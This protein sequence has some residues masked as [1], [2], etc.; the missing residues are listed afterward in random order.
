[1]SYKAAIMD[2]PES[3]ERGRRIYIKTCNHTHK[4][5]DAA[6]A[7]ATQLWHQTFGVRYTGTNASYRIDVVEVA[8]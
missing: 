5:T 1:M 4:R 8:R 2:V 6:V 3:R 7:C